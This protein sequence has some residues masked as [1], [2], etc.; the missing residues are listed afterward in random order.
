MKKSFV[1]LALLS[2]SA[3]LL[4]VSCKKEEED[5]LGDPIVTPD[6]KVTENPDDKT[7]K[8]DNPV[9]ETGSKL[10]TLCGTTAC[11]FPINVLEHFMP[12][13][14]YDTGEQTVGLTLDSCGEAVAYKNQCV[15]IVYTYHNNYWGAHFQ[16]PTNDKPWGQYYQ[17]SKSA[18]TL[19]FKVKMNSAANIT[20]NA[21]GDVKYGKY[22]YYQKDNHPLDVWITKTITLKSVPDSI[23]TPLN[24]VIDFD[25][26]KKPTVGQKVIVDIKDLQ[27]ED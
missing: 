9:V 8:D 21:F 13:G 1:F 2:F 5:S 27:F 18:K 10:P 26:D 24:I 3:L 22:E 15:R 19:S 17:I 11:T 23:N 12:S 7:P 4:T 6:D 16:D 14:F 20:L 25:A